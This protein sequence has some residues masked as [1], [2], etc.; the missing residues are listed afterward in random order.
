MV[1]AVPFLAR[2]QDYGTFVVAGSDPGAVVIAADSGLYDGN[3]QRTGA[4]CKLRIVDG[5][6]LAQGGLHQLG[7]LNSLDVAEGVVRV[8]PVDPAERADLLGIALTDWIDSGYRLLGEDLVPVVRERQPVVSVL[9]AW[10][11]T[12]VGEHRAGAIERVELWVIRV[13]VFAEPPTDPVPTERLVD[14]CNRSA[15][16]A[17]TAQVAETWGL[18]QPLR[19]RRHTVV[20]Q[21][22]R[23]YH[24]RS[25][26]VIGGCE[27]P[28][29]ALA[30]NPHFW[31][32]HDLEGAVILVLRETQDWPDRAA[33][34]VTAACLDA[35]GARWLSR[36][37]CGEE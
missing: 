6:L 4:A 3:H 33:R 9:W 17:A 28:N 18:G 30:V 29:R 11:T 21:D 36:G 15:D 24:G 12:Q 32:T 16:A 35:F 23:R 5:A 13:D 20:I 37:Q 7:R 1:L 2:G 26:A 31:Q 22:P 25:Q 8:A 14:P 10:N 27:A 19:W 34:P